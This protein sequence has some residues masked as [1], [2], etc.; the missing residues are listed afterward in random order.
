MVPAT[1]VGQCD[2]SSILQS[3]GDIPQKKSHPKGRVFQGCW[4][5]IACIKYTI[6]LILYNIYVHIYR[7][8]YVVILICILLNAEIAVFTLRFRVD[9][10]IL[11]ISSNL[12][13]ARG[14][15]HFVWGDTNRSPGWYQ[16]LSSTH[17]ALSSAPRCHLSISGIVYHT[18]RACDNCDRPIEA[19]S[20]NGTVFIG[21]LE[22]HGEMI[23]LKMEDI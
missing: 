9:H 21:E 16:A 18:K 10:E 13:L 3:R 23:H 19:V 1:C 12:I 11:R 20:Q 6:H 17:G 15:R 4:K 14:F 5:G 2:R 8:D 22:Q 7:Y